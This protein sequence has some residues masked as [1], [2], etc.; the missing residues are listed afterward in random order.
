VDVV[1]GCNAGKA[2][3]VEL[4]RRGIWWVAA[5][6]PVPIL[7]QSRTHRYR[8]PDAY[9]SIPVGCQEYA[10][11]NGSKVGLQVGIRTHRC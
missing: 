1:A 4:L 8:N 7:N 2:G 6:R 9:F 5:G 10:S 11:E 3:G